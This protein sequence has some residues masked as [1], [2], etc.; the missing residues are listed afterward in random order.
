MKKRIVGIAGAIAVCVLV[1]IL[2]FGADS[3]L[4]NKANT[5]GT[6]GKIPSDAVTVTGS[7]KGLNGPVELEVTATDNHIYKIKVVSHSETQGIGTV[8]L[9]QLPAEII[10]EQSINVDVVSGA[11]ITSNAIKNAIIN[12]FD[13]AGLD[14]KEIQNR[15]V[16]SKTAAREDKTYTTDVVVIGAGGAGMTAAIEAKDA[17]CNVIVI[18]STTMVGG[19]S[20]RSTG[21]IN[22]AETPY[23]QLNA[24][25]EAAGVEKM[26]KSAAADTYKDNAE[27]QSL[28]ATVTKQWEAYKANPQGYFDSTELFRLDTMIGGGGIND[29]VLVKTLAEDSNDAIEWLDSIGGGMPSVSSFGGASVKRIHRPVDENNKTLSVGTYI[30]PILQKNLESRGIELLLEHTAVELITDKNGNV[31]GVIA[32]T[33]N[34]SKI[35]INA[36]AVV[37]AT[38]G[39]GSNMDLIAK[40]RPDLY[41][42]LSTNAPGIQGQG[43]ILAEDVGAALVDIDQ[44]Q[45]HPTV[46]AATASLI[47]EGLRGDGAILINQNGERFYDEVSTRDKVSAAEFAQ[48]GSIAWLIVDGK[49]ADASTV[50]QGYIKKGLTVTGNSYAELAA[51]MGVPADA[52]EKTMKTWNGYVEAKNDPDFGRTSFA[53]PLDQAP[54]YAIRVTPGIHHTM[55]GVKINEKTQVINTSGNVISGLFAAGEVTGGVHGNNRLGGNAVADF[56]VFGRI[57][58]QQAAALA[59][60]K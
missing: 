38:G 15:A 8:A 60:S 30:V 28:L 31:C 50:I 57:A 54:Y 20:I 39:Y 49:M 56:V 1:I 26:L 10:A 36:K 9:E 7:A 48:P 46:E 13:N 11:T 24:F 5:V 44:I 33:P 27:I 43:L 16:A 22:A 58:G 3:I 45:L 19:N 23:Q 2:C 29:P 52:F 59:K 18:E 25:G 55:G 53:K 32:E 47:T 6:A 14:S 37:L 35:T 41:G 42:F 40:Y 12:A 21:G 51:A 4:K 34:G 17:G